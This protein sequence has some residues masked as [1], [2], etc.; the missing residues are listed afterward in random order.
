MSLLIEKRRIIE[1]DLLTNRGVHQFNAEP[2][3]SSLKN[4]ELCSTAYI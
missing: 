3:L 4:I 1:I 2:R